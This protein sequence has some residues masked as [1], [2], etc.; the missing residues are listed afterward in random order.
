MAFSLQNFPNFSHAFFITLLFAE[1]Y[2]LIKA[3][4]RHARRTRQQMV[5]TGEDAPPIGAIVHGA[6]NWE[7][8][9][10][11]GSRERFDIERIG[12][13]EALK[14]VPPAYGQYRGSVRIAD[15]DIR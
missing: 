12:V 4:L 14:P 9:S 10:D 6:S 15:A 11:D 2:L 13:V 5:E 3:L 1:F 7:G 8:A